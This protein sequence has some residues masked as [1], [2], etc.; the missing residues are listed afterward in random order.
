MSASGASGRQAMIDLLRST[1]TIA[2]VG[3]SDRPER[4]S[5]RV[6]AYLQAAGYRVVPVNPACTEVLGERCYPDLSAVPA[7]IEIDLVDVFRRPEAVPEVV[8]QVVA[9][10]VPALWLQLGVGHPEAE[11]RARRAGVTVVS[12][13]C[14]EVD[15]A[16][17][18]GAL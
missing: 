13:R 3:C 9:R 2:V 4:D 11:A 14:L 15:H 16:A 8:E 6:A 5:Y 18:V 1:R 10:G 12:D 17:L 7:E